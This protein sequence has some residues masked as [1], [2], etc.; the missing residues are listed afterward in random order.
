M[1]DVNTY[2][3]FRLDHSKNDHYPDYRIARNYDE[4]VFKLGPG[5]AGSYFKITKLGEVTPAHMFAIHEL[6]NFLK[7]DVS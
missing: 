1:S 5:L 6:L 4:L 2:F 3:F 7:H